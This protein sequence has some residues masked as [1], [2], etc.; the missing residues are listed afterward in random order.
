MAEGP[1]RQ[2]RFFTS[3][4][5]VPPELLAHTYSEAMEDLKKNEVQSPELNEILNQIDFDSLLGI[6]RDLARSCGVSSEQANL[7]G[8]DNV[9]NTAGVHKNTQ[10]E[11]GAYSAGRNV[12]FLNIEQIL[13]VCKDHAVDKRL[14]VLFILCHELAHAL[15][16]N[17]IKATLPEREAKK[18]I[19]AA[20]FI[21]EKIPIINKKVNFGSQ[22]R[23]SGYS[24]K[25]HHEV[26]GG[27][28]IKEELFD[29]FD[30]GVN[31]KMGEYIFEEYIKRCGYFV[32]KE[33]LE[34][35]RKRLKEDRISYPKEVDFVNTFIKKISERTGV[36]EMTVWQ[37]IVEGKMKGT[38]LMQ[39]DI[40]ELFDEM[41]GSELLKKLSSG[42]FRQQDLE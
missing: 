11:L 6:M 35:F 21:L 7:L 34:K 19:S 12:I 22:E 33:A 9:V 29:R 28:G 15:S 24:R 1:S 25:K 39:G 32:D 31:E 10:G 4:G 20:K 37:G 42:N 26:A 30:E 41:F 38:D 13:K 3:F 17:E 5:E 40:K 27:I 18:L 14:E 36:P 2:V 23:V 8:R 16:K